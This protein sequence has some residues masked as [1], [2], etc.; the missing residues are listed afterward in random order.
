MASILRSTL[1]RDE[2]LARFSSPKTNNNALCSLVAFDRFLES[3]YA[4]ISEAIMLEELRKSEDEKYI[5]L[6]AMVQHWISLKRSHATIQNYFSFV[7]SY[8]RSQGVKTTVE[9]V[10]QYVIF[11]KKIKEIRR[12]LSLEQIKLMFERCE[13]RTRALLLVLVSSGMRIGEALTL[14]KRNFDQTSQPVKVSIPALITKTKEERETYISTEAYEVLKPILDEINDNDRVFPQSITGFQ[15]TFSKL[16]KRCGLHK[17]K[18]HDGRMHHVN[19]HAFRAFFHTK[20]T[21]VHGVEYAHA[22]IGHGSYLQQYFRLEAKERLQMYITLEP[23]V[24]IYNDEITRS[25]NT[26]LKAQ[27]EKQKV[28]ELEIEKMKAHIARMEHSRSGSST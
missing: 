16:R 26:N 22:V 25:E 7:R 19:I 9:D 24:T 3:K 15:N 17:E 21:M 11:P 14:E 18:Y 1:S 12:P 6:D 13:W 8:L 20:A 23:Y 10:K 28:L 4:G 2:W 27:L 5:F